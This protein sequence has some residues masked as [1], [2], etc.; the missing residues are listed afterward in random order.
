VGSLR[1]SYRQ[2]AALPAFGLYGPHGE[3]VATVRARSAPEARD[4]FRA[5][6]LVGARVKRITP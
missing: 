4:L 6:G 2:V 3:L 5:H 1:R